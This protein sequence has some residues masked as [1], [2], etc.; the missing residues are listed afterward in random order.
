MKYNL[1]EVRKEWQNCQD[2][3]KDLYE[4]AEDD[5]R[6]LHG[7]D[8]W[9]ESAK[10]E[11]EKQKRPALTLNQLL[12]YAQ[13]LV[14]DIRQARLAIRVSPVDSD[15]DV[16]TAEVLAGVIRN[17]ERQS[18]AQ[19]VYSTAALHAIGAGMG[20][21]KVDVDYADEMSF[22]QEISIE[23]VLDFTS[24]YLDPMAQ[25]IDGSDADYAFIRVDYTKEEFEALYPDREPVS[26]DDEHSADADICVMEYYKRY[27]E[28]V[29]IYN[30]RLIDGQPR[31]ITQEQKDA[32]DEDGTVAYEL[33]AERKTK[34]PY[35]KKCVL[36]GEETPIEEEEFPSK[37]LPIVPVYGVEAWLNEQREF[38][39]FIRQAKDAQKM[40]NY[41]KSASTEF[42]A[43]QPKA[44]WTAPVGS[45]A[46]SPDRWA[47]ANTE[48]IAALEYD[49]VYDENGQRAEPPKREQPIQG[50]P[51]MMQEAIG[52]R[53]DIR[54][55]LGMPQANMGERGA[56]VSGIAIRNRQIE[57][58]N[59]TFH[60]MDH[61]AASITQLGRILVDIIP[62]IYT[63]QK[64]LRII[65]ENGDEENITVNQGGING[66][67]QL[68]LGK[69]DIVTDVGASYSSKRQETADKT[70]ELIRARP[71]LAD[72]V[73]D[74]LFEALDLPMGK[75]IAERIKST[76]DPALLGDDPQ[77]ARLMAMGE[78]MKALEEQVL[79]YQAALDDKAKN[80]QFDQNV[81]LKEL[82]L[83]NKDLA[84]KA[85]KTAAEI[86]KMA[87]E[88]K[89]TNMDAVMA[90]GN[91]VQSL[92]EDLTDVKGALEVMID[93]K[94]TEV[95]EVTGAPL[96]EPVMPME[97][98]NE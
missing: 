57:G 94:E 72:I 41:W 53:E 6:F 12:P 40:Y 32:I 56:E 35:V 65:G 81:Q 8:Q 59:A 37:Y 46:S 58:D 69:Y 78:A 27:Y 18:N 89:E 63:E 88:T 34:I 23:R 50:S 74:L 93:A 66:M 17:I 71:E 7:I 73:G 29:S 5:W 26:F 39:S 92:F 42:I 61:L 98:D 10:K 80:E 28:E 1:E 97:G 76:M 91:V 48:N 43:L 60:F 15:A 75:E 38:H 77:A 25:R 49:L 19:T 44:P 64:V 96:E 14:N 4:E 47:N 85:Q 95:N 24:V 86:Q 54:L 70:I 62:R 3:V 36:N 87:A 22:D 31:V 90:L 13:Q 84:I 68:G 21:I 67:Y 51:A 55:G 83:K 9:P 30:V 79:N 20:W 45:F 33:L 52:A 82:D 2:A 11:R 16:E